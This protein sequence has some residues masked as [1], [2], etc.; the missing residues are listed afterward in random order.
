MR[1]DLFAQSF[2]GLIGN[3]ATQEVSKWLREL[4]LSSR[5]LLNYR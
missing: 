5:S 4:N 1:L 3:F 2:P